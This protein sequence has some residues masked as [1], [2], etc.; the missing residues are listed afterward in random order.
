MVNHICEPISS[1]LAAQLAWGKVGA[2]RRIAELDDM[3]VGQ[4]PERLADGGAAGER[5]EVRV[6]RKETCGR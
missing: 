3:L 6:R 1:H 2:E 4:T 5:G